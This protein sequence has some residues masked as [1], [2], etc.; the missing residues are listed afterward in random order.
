MQRYT[1]F[2]MQA[3]INKE[4]M[5]PPQLQKKYRNPMMTFHTALRRVLPTFTLNCS[6]IPAKHL[7]LL[8]K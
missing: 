2:F 3:T 6:M 4:K 1:Q 5:A 8:G 7:V